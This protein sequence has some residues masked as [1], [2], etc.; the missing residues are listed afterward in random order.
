M[1]TTSVYLDHAATTPV[2]P[3]V[4]EAMLPYLGPEA[5]GNPSSAHAFGRTARAGLDQARRDVAAA[6]DAEPNQ[7]IFTSGGTEADNLAIIGA[8]IA[9]RDRGG[10]MCAVVSAIEH[11]A[12]LAAAHAV[13]HLGGEEIILPVDHCGRI[14]LSALEEALAGQPAIVSTMWVNNEVGVV[15][16]VDEIASRCRAAQVCFHT[17]GVQAFGKV[18]VSLKSLDCTLLSLSGHKIGAPK[19]IGALI[20]RDRKALESIIHGGGQQYGLR[21]GTENVAGAVGM[22]VAAR[23][24]AAAQEAESRRVGAL[25]DEL[26][27]RLC[28]AIP[29]AVVHAADGPRAPHVLSISVP[30]ADA[31][32]LLMHLDLAGIAASAGSACS[33]GAVEPSHV[34]TALGVPREVALGTIRFSLGHETT[35]DDIARVAEVFPTAVA[36]V[37]EL[38]GALSRD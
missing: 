20:V 37:R 4:L 12:I 28:A 27:A 1:T 26:Q 38:V 17:D 8:A 9:A 33:T 23:L 5:F 14:V 30:G 21:P 34:L 31:Q 6:V 25:R 7:V 35:A 3:E 16:A 18:P 15:Q 19:G 11:K 2:R 32:A 24:A 29:E 10:R 36:R 13:C 22:G